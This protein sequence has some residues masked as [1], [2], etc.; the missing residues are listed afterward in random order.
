MNWTAWPRPAQ[1]PAHQSHGSGAGRPQGRVTQE[2]DA[3]W[4][5][6]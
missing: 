2:R 1:P 4:W 5:G 3:E 6:G